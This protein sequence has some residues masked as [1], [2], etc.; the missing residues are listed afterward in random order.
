MYG[1]GVPTRVHV[2]VHIY[3]LFN[4]VYVKTYTSADVPTNITYAYTG[5]RARTHTRTHNSNARS[6]SAQEKKQKKKK[7]KIHVPDNM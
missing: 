1:I 4:D 2:F 5:T 6:D 7:N 3:Y